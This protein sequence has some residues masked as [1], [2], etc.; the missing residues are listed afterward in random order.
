MP[1]IIPRWEWRTFGD[2]FPKAEAI[3][4]GLEP[5]NVVET[6]ELY[7]VAPGDNNIK[8][9][10]DLMDIKVLRATDA[11]G[12]ERWEPILK[13]A[14]PLSPADERTVFD[15]LGV[16]P[17]DSGAE[18]LT[19]NG[20]LD[21]LRPAGAI[22]PVEVNKRRVRY[23]V[24]GCMAERSEINAEG[25]TTWTVAVES[26]D[27]EAVVKA[28]DSLGF[29][30]YLNKS[31]ETGLAEL[32]DDMPPR[33]AVIDV[34]TNS[35][36]FH[37][38]ERRADGTWQTVVDR[39]EVTR[40]GEGFADDGR[41][42]PA[43]LE[44]TIEAISGMAAEARRD[45]VVAIAAVG[46]EAVRS[47][48]NSAEA[49]T[50]IHDR[51]RIRVEPIPGEE[52]ARLAYVAAVSSLGLRGS[53]LVAFDT[54][55]GSSQF[56]FG[57]GTQIDEQFSVPVGAARYTERF[58]LDRAVSAATIQEALAAIAT[59][60]QRLDA[61]PSPNALVGMGGTLTNMTAVK[62][63]LAI[64]DPDRV[65]GTVLDRAEIDRQIEL[66]RARDADG[67]RTIVG[68]Q[69]KRAEVIL[70]G[71]CVVRAVLEKLGADSVTVSDRALRHGLLV[72]RFGGR[73]ASG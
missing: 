52:E 62:H 70:A 66:F 73:E 42:T 40:L 43:A 57:D 12:L 22:R 41:I 46:T 31:Y 63:E 25:R 50:M 38:G 18:P 35:V 59:D 2:R 27:D 17:R 8:I 16:S 13:A 20:L 34:G 36:K 32:L 60:L 54:G 45:G 26:P 56:T 24:G 69:P 58:G 44:R 67:R 4:D 30:E 71:A 37:I 28:V 72:E 33:Y 47:A 61:R 1:E 55:G 65:H 14:F 29:G 11:N 39:A 6:D 21:I 53:G 3:F 9:R 68:L 64:Y 51:T 19:L 23:T 7:L 49:R 10:N 5:S 48:K 15:A